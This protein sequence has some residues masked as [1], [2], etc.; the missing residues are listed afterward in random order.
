[1]GSE[2]PESDLVKSGRRDFLPAIGRDEAPEMS[3]VVRDYG[4]V[5]DLQ[6]MSSQNDVR[7]QG[8][9]RRKTSETPIGPQTGSSPH[10]WSRQGKVSQETAKLIQMVETPGR[11]SATSKGKMEEASPRF[12]VSDLRYAEKIVGA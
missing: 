11:G 4:G 8:R 2:A 10:D 7:I 5:R 3:Q 12:V 6:S 1:M 9:S